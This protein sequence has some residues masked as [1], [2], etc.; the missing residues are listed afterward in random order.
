MRTALLVTSVLATLC[1]WAQDSTRTLSRFEIGITGTF[2]RSYRTLAA[3]ESGND[4]SYIMDRR[5]DFEIPLAG[6]SAGLEIAFTA[7][8]RW[9][10]ESGIR[11]SMTG[12]ATDELPVTTYVSPEGNLNY[13]AIPS[14]A[15]FLSHY[16]YVG[17]PLILRYEF[18]KRKL[19]FAPAIGFIGET[20]L[21]QTAV[22]ILERQ[23]GHES[24][25]SFSDT[26]TEY[27]ST[28][29]SAYSDVGV[30]Y[31]FNEHL[32]MRLAAT[33]R[34]QL[35]ELVNAPITA[36]LWSVGFLAGLRYHF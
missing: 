14:T 7:C 1:A 34:Y 2:E 11:Y 35:T 13:P 33:G 8:Y 17:V 30:I 12:W 29:L 3:T 9:H 28:S 19:H 25:E 10:V 26:F 5:D 16:H 6:Y 32:G 36:H 23:D 15:R 22:F 21:D 4:Y 27:N 31:R 24:R 20:L 18:G